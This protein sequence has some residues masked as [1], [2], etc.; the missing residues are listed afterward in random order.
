MDQRDAV[1]L[2]EQADD[3]F[4]LA[5]PHQPV[6]DEHTGQLVADRLMDENGGDRRLHS[7]RQAADDACRADLLADFSDLCVPEPGHG[8]VPR[9]PADLA[10]EIGEQPRA[11]G[12][13]EE[14]QSW[15]EGTMGSERVEE[16]V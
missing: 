15:G 9:K 8:P 13:M 1:M 14:R 7:A 6:V 5:K 16:G 10:A 4:C 12:R 11:N 2:A 3:L